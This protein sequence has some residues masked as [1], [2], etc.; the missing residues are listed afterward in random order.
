MQKKVGFFL[1]LVLFLSATAAYAK[2]KVLFIESYHSG[3]VW[4][5]EL[6]R[7]LESVL[8]DK[9]GLSSFQMDTKRYRINQYAERADL[10]WQYYLEIKPDVVVLSDDNALMLLADR[11][12]RTNTPVVYMGINNNPRMY[13]PLGQNITGVLERP[14]CKRTVKYLKELLPIRDG[15]VLILLDKSTT[16]EVFKSSVFQ[17]KNSLIISGVNTDIKLISSFTDWKVAVLQ[18]PMHNCRAIVIGLYHRIF[19][20]GVHVDS[21]EVLRWTSMNSPVPVF[22]F[23]V[24]SVGKDKAV[25]GMVLDGEEQGKNAG[26]IVLDILNGIPVNTIAPVVPTQG[27]FIFSRSE[28]DKWKIRLPRHIKDHARMVE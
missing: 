12:L 11:L 26:K 4:D 8:A 21:E 20:R 23:W 15:K 1:F 19:D 5:Q 16:T 22:A 3:Y 25:G 17:D 14:L 10:A 18:A 24:M 28:L 13:A 9:V 2:P 27:E 7:G 6:R